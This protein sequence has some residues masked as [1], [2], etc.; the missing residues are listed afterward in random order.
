MDPTAEGGKRA[1]EQIVSGAT[2]ILKAPL[3]FWA[4]KKFFAGIPYQD[5]PVNFPV[6]LRGIPGLKEAARALGFADQNRRGDW[7]INDKHLG[8]IENMLPFISRFR[9]FI[10]EDEKTQDGWLRT[11][12]SSG[13]GLS[14]KINTHRLQRSEVI[15]R[16][17][18][19]EDDRRKKR[20]WRNTLT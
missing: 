4:E 1:L 7:L 5:K 14:V 9:R 13:A 2:P 11:M 18:R 12:L 10:P 19:R 8:F 15:R 16:R 17:I 20:A 3:E 6:A